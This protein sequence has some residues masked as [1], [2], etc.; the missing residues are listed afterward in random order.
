MAEDEARKIK[1]NN[2][3]KEKLLI[4]NREPFSSPLTPF[5]IHKEHLQLSYHLIPS[6]PGFTWSLPY[7][8]VLFFKKI[9]MC[10]SRNIHD[11]SPT[12]RIGNSWECGG[13]SKAPKFK[14]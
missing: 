10:S 11:T 4:Y 14:Y 13:F 6:D 2:K 5:S 12:E 3:W 9:E 1:Y 7:Y 8:L